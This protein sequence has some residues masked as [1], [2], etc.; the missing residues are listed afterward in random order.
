[1]A[2]FDE[3]GGANQQCRVRLGQSRVTGRLAADFFGIIWLMLSG[4]GDII[5]AAAS[6]NI[7]VGLVG[8]SF[9]FGLTVPTLL[10]ADGPTSGSPPKRPTAA[11]AG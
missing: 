3:I 4:C 2:P 1:L 10:Q 11:P 7:S 5:L 8:F 9:A 6:P